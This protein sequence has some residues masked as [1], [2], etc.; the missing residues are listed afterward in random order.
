MFKD[1]FEHV[2]WILGLLRCICNCAPFLS[3]PEQRF[4]SNFIGLYVPVQAR[5]ARTE[6]NGKWCNQKWKES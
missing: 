1:F 3:K 5:G 2:K 4:E 6:T